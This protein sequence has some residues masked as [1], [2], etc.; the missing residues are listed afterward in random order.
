MTDD[1]APD[2]EFEREVAKRQMYLLADREARRRLAAA[3]TEDLDLLAAFPTLDEFLAQED[4]PSRFRIEGL[5]PSGGAKIMCAAQ[6]KTGKTTLNMNLI[7]SLADGDAFLDSFEVHERAQRIV[8]MDNEMNEDMLRYWIRLQ[9]IRNTSAVAGVA[10]LRDKPRLLDLGNDRVREFWVH[11]LRDLGCD[12]LIFDCLKPA[13][14]VMGLDENHEIGKFLAPFSQLLADAG[15][16]DVIVYHHMGHNNERAR[17]DST[18]VGW[19]D[20]NL[21]LIRDQMN[22]EDRYFSAPDVRGAQQ[23]VGEGL[24]S[25]NPATQRLSYAG[26]DRIQT[27]E[28]GVVEDRATRILEVLAE[29]VADAKN[30]TNTLNRTA[31][32]RAVGGKDETTKKALDILIDTRKQVIRESVGRALL[33]KLA[34]KANDPTDMGAEPYTL[35]AP[36][37]SPAAGRAS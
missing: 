28:D 20:A 7:R 22:P 36:M 27:H 21:K 34:P 4:T 2:A 35:P 11:R 26:G 16:G 33:Y 1:T 17:G 24:L 15:I 23:P 37:P 31:L 32:Y 5:W 14:D 30:D 13:L 9:K 18:L 3:D 6:A 19:T 12:L 29:A 8:V 25:F 10:A